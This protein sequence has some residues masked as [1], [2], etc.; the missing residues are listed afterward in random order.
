MERGGRRAADA[1]DLARMIELLCERGIDL[2]SEGWCLGVPRADELLMGGAGPV[3][4]RRRAD[5]ERRHRAHLRRGH[6]AGCRE[7]GVPRE[8]LARFVRGWDAV[9]AAGLLLE[10]V[11]Q[12]IAEI[13]AASAQRGWRADLASEALWHALRSRITPRG[14]PERRVPATSE[15]AAGT[16]SRNGRQMPRSASN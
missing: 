6:D 10:A 5:A 13:C 2:R 9:G 7:L 11:D 3:A 15:E 1:R 12:A 14:A 4:G 16:R 8:T